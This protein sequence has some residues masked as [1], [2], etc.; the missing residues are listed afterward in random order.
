MTEF[1]P[2]D[3]VQHPGKPEWGTGIVLT[4]QQ[5]SHE[6]K[7][8]QRLTVRF[9]AAGKKTINT[10]FASL[11]RL[12]GTEP[13]PSAP[14]QSKPARATSK[15]PS[16]TPAPPRERPTPA[17]PP[18]KAVLT[19]RL[20][21]LPHGL[22][23]PFRGIEERLADTV[24]AYRYRPGDRSLLEWAVAQTGVADPLSILGRHE[25]EEQYATFRIR[26][27]RH[28][29]ALLEEARRAR[30]EPRPIINAAPPEARAEVQHAL[31]RINPG[32]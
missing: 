8:C 9:S 11:A 29:K 15:T 27:D 26:L 3:Q 24:L 14:A 30:I 32:R 5:A 2:N 19:E 21:T 16:R 20:A 7:P 12:G 17:P 25:L 22:A 4:T 18:D 23:D 13:N 1:S 28:L 31:R 6:G 10:A